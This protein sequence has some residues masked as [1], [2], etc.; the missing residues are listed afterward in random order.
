MDGSL[1]G[2]LDGVESMAAD[3]GLAGGLVSVVIPTY[4]RAEMV[5]EAVDSAMRQTYKDVE[6]VVVDDGST[7]GTAPALREKYADGVTVIRRECNGGTPSSVNMGIRASR[8]RWIRILGSDD[9]MAPSALSEFVRAAARVEDPEKCLFFSDG[10]LVDRD[11]RRSRVPI[12]SSIYNGS[13]KM[14]AAARAALGS[15]FLFAPR[16][17]FETYGYLREDLRTSEDLEWLLRMLL[18]HDFQFHV[19]NKLLLEYMQHAGS[20]TGTSLEEVLA[21]RD[22]VLRD[23]A[24]RLGPSDGARLLDEF[25]QHD[26]EQSKTGILPSVK[27]WALYQVFRR[28]PRLYLA[29]RRVGDGFDRAGDP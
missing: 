23:A 5:T 1:I 2:D 20:T 8:G 14:R 27:T 4:N 22:A 7:D 21:S 28:V 6:V 29:Y 26:S 16:S 13:D 17:A 15:G 11:N 24:D 25:R 9:V 10:W 19:V 3:D 18:M 12:V